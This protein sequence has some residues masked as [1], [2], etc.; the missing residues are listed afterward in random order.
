MTETLQ[1]PVLAPKEERQDHKP[2]KKSSL[3]KASRS[4]EAAK[5]KSSSEVSKSS[6]T[7]STGA[8]SRELEKISTEDTTAAK[9]SRSRA[10]AAA[11]ARENANGKRPT[12]AAKEVSVLAP[13]EVEE[14]SAVAPPSTAECPAIEDPGIESDDHEEFGSSATSEDSQEET[15][16]RGFSAW[17]AI[18]KW[19]AGNRLLSVVTVALVV[20]VV[21]L[22]M[23]Q[24]SLNRDNSITGAR[25]SALATAKSYAV[26]L[27]SYNYKKLNQDFGK[28]LAESTPTF[29][30]DFT[31]DS[32]ALKS[33][34]TRYDASAQANVIAAGLVSATTSRAVVLV[35]LNQTVVNTLQKNKPTT[36]SRVELTL[37]R[38]GGRWLIDQVTLL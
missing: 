31:Q 23:T 16:R 26:D 25:T 30:Q 2:A 5:S 7:G 18:R 11:A 10:T 38:S 17:S 12:L 37:L 24:L 13:D 3:A 6:R 15:T 35:F 33:T 32:N 8:A 4:K 20:A 27:A 28:V 22:V 9:D 14:K 21:L 29:K 1:A 19:V 36:E 34:L